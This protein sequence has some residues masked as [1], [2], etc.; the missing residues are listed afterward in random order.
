[1]YFKFSTRKLYSYTL[2]ELADVGD[3]QYV[4]GLMSGNEVRDWLDLGPIDGLE[5]L[6]MLENYIPAEM[7]G[8]QKKLKGDSDDGNK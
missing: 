1:M 4:R 5:E 2:T 8:N 3:A 6:V 7:I